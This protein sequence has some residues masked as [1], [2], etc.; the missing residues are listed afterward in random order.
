VT[1]PAAILLAATIAAPVN[2]QTRA[3]LGIGIGSVRY[4]RD[5]TDTVGTGTAGG[6][7]FSTAAFSPT[8]QYASPTLTVDVS[9]SFASLPEGVW[10][11]QGRGGLWAQTRPFAGGWRV[12]G[13]AIVTGTTSPGGGRTAAAQGM[14]ELSWSALR[15]GFGVG[16]G[17]SAGWIANTTPVAALHMRARAW[18]RPA[19]SRGTSEWQASAEPTR[20]PDG[21]FTDLGAGGTVERGPLVASLWA[22]ARLQGA[23]SASAAAGSAFLQVFVFPR[24]S[25]ELGGGS[26]L[27]DPYQG[28][29]Q[30]GY[31]TVGV[32]LHAA[33]HVAA[34]QRATAAHLSPLVPA[35]RGDS[36]VVRFHFS[37][38]RTV[39]VA[40]DWNQWR[41]LPLLSLGG[42]L[43]E[44]KLALPRGVYHFNVL[45]DGKTWVVPNGIA[46][47][48]DGLG[49]MV[50]VLVVP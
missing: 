12:G 27:R 20:L 22:A 31:I 6:R 11:S 35:S 37:N 41:Q 8:L 1:R 19:A 32:R 36:L 30:A 25:L 10:S 50:G 21:W 23:P 26:Y 45:L 46:A 3:S 17:P 44:G 24:A 18:W 29:P 43:W 39:A 2:G 13:E 15:W 33:R 49:G 40:G 42:D 48:S 38:A 16:A 14:G 34:A 9:G 5:A 4:A 28:L 47:V 7:A